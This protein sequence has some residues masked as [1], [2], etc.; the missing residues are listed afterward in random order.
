MDISVIN[1]TPEG[2]ETLV[3]EP[4]AYRIDANNFDKIFNECFA[5]L[6][7]RIGSIEYTPYFVTFKPW[8]KNYNEEHMYKNG[9]SNI[10]RWASL[11]NASLSIFT[12]EE[13]DCAKVHLNGL[14]YLPS[15]Q[16]N[17][18]WHDTFYS[19]RYKVYCKPVESLSDCLR[20]ILKE[21]K[22][23]SYKL[24]RDYK[25]YGAYA[26]TPKK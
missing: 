8:N 15:D 24:G 1:I 4:E 6:K 5:Y 3:S 26:K 9:L 2:E 20:Y 23:R 18:K 7:P 11:R 13:M 25:K 19:H 17:D 22:H 14:L 21:S 12:L 16:D 10:T